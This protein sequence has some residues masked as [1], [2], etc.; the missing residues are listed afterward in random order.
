MQPED[1]LVEEELP[2][3]L[4][5]TGEHLWLR[6]R[7]RGL[8]S[9]QAAV[10]LGRVANVLR[11]DVGY[12]GMKDR[13]AETIQ[14]FSLLMGQRPTP[15]WSVLPAGLEILETTRHA[16]KLKTGA[17]SGNRFVVTLRDCAG[18][19]GSVME[20]IELIRQLRQGDYD[21]LVGINLL[22]A[23]LSSGGCHLLRPIDGGQMAGCK[24]LTY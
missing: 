24:L 22:Q 16:R 9:E 5:G 19:I 11:R 14:W 23:R 20:R 2:F 4:T 17:L 15:D 1:F 10:A 18:D 7:K 3:T 8:N 12:A 6:I 13:H 21:A